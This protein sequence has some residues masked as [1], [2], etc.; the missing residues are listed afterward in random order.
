M[1]RAK[2]TAK[3]QYGQF[4]ALG[5]ADWAREH[6]AHTGAEAVLELVL[7]GRSG[8]VRKGAVDL[9]AVMGRTDIL[10]ELTRSD[11]DSGVRNRAAKRL[12]VSPGQ[13]TLFDQTG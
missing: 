5:L 8:T 9:A 2:Q 3:D 7:A 1:N 13:G 11:P 12:G 4:L 6:P 10:A